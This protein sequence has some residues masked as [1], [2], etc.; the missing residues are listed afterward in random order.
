MDE[1]EHIAKQIKTN[2]EQLDNNCLE[3]L[4]QL[5]QEKRKAR[6][7]YQE[8]HSKIATQFSHVST[9]IYSV[10]YSNEK[11]AINNNCYYGVRTNMLKYIDINVNLESP[12]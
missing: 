10:F 6:K 12:S 7:Q 8:E 1:L 11:Y 5:Y 2:A 4:S 3:K 9:T